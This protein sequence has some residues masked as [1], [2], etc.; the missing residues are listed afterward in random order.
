M[1][2]PKKNYTNADIW[3]KLDNMASDIEM[4]KTW[5]ISQ[6]AGKAAVDEYKRREVNE[7]NNQSKDGVYDSIKDLIPYIIAVLAAFAAYIYVHTSGVGK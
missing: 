1:T 3:K 2:Q 4:L 5:K 6:D 7:K